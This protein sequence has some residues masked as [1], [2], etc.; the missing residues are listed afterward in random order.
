MSSNMTKTA[1]VP[2]SQRTI[3]ELRTKATELREM[4]ATAR[5]DWEISALAT[6][7]ERYDALAEC[8]AVEEQVAYRAAE[9]LT[10][11]ITAD[12]PQ[13]TAERA[14]LIASAAE[15]YPICPDTR[16][17]HP[18]LDAWQLA[19]ERLSQRYTDPAI[20]HHPAAMRECYKLAC[21]LMAYGLVP[22]T[23]VVPEPWLPEQSRDAQGADKARHHILVV[24]DVNDVLVTV[25]AFLAKAGF[26]IRKA[27]NGDEA[28][29]LIAS[30]PSID[31]LVT[32][33]A[34]PGLSGGELILLAAQIRPDLKSMIITGY[35][36]ADGLTEL[37]PGTTILVK[38][39]RRNALIAGITSLLGEVP[40]VPDETIGSEELAQQSGT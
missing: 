24:D 11:R 26:P 13:Q 6:L 37:P 7:G 3:W 39:F 4:A 28:I 27:S 34:M 2:L 5:T 10:R 19:C 31:V 17:G 29:R 21:M 16:I 18:F 12:T 22:A 38:P 23:R 35:P 8:R 30:D 1:H 15:A 33:Y 32:D 9:A 25:G 20:L 40:L 36:N 14:P